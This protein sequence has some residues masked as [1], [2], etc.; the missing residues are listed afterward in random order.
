M[1]P[2]QAHGAPSDPNRNH[3]LGG[4]SSLAD[5][6]HHD[7]HPS[8]EA[9]EHDGSNAT[10]ESASAAEERPAEELREEEKEDLE[11]N[12]IEATNMLRLRTKKNL[13]L[14]HWKK[15]EEKL[16]LEQ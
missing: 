16:S 11:L 13:M 10:P 5:G 7:S 9:R 3:P 14:D 2:E 12:A 4:S 8:I 15:E 6:V 1:Q